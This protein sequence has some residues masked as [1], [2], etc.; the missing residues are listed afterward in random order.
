MAKDLPADR[1]L[2]LEKELCDLRKQEE[3]LYAGIGRAACDKYG[4]EAFGDLSD[5]LKELEKRLERTCRDLDQ[6]VAGFGGGDRKSRRTRGRIC[7]C[8]GYENPG[9]TDHCDECGARLIAWE[10]LL[11]A[12]CG[13]ELSAGLPFCG[14]CGSRLQEER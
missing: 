4:A 5:R 8:C 9:E 3:G 7:S 1:I 10:K 2:V 12:E 6:A 14:Q 11:C 13:S